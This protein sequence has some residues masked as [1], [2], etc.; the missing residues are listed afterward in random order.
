MTYK[1]TCIKVSKSGQITEHY[2]T[3][4]NPDKVKRIVRKWEKKGY[5]VQ[6]Q[7]SVI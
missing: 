6:V 2:E 3:C 5:Y 4:S 7:K 1:I